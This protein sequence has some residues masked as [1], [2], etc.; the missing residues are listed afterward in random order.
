YGYSTGTVSEKNIYADIRAVY[1]YIHRT[2]PNKKIVLLGYSIGT[3]AVIDLAASHPEGVSGRCSGSTVHERL[4]IAGQSPEKRENTPFTV[5]TSSGH[6]LIAVRCPPSRPSYSLRMRKQV[7]IF[8]QPNSSDLGS[9]LQPRYVN[10]PQFAEIFEMDVYGFDY[11][12]KADP[13]Y[14]KTKGNAWLSYGGGVRLATAGRLLV[15]GHLCGLCCYIGC[16]PIPESIARKL[17]F[18]PPKKG[19]SYTVHLTANP[20][21]TIKGADEL[22][23]RDFII[24]PTPLEL[25]TVFDYERLLTRIKEHFLLYRTAQD[26]CL[27]RL[28]PKNAPRTPIP[29]KNPNTSVLKPNKYQHPAGV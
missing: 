3:T 28:H 6:H 26:K 20:D 5:R 1:E 12:G 16:P 9:F 4:A 23:G 14:S 29:S 11:S 24:T 15:S 17:A 7:V 2:R 13:I 21:K 25:T 10:L 22:E 8:T 18:H 27:L 19:V